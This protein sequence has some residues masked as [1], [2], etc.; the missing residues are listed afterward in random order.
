[1]WHWVLADLFRATTLVHCMFHHCFLV[2]VLELQNND[3]RLEV[4][5]LLK[6]MLHSF[7]FSNLSVIQSIPD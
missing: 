1:M 2:P 7:C 3:I 4:F 6:Q 5:L